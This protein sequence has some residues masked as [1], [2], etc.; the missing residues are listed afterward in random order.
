MAFCNKWVP[1]SAMAM[2]KAKPVPGTAVERIAFN[3]MA[4]PQGITISGNG[5]VWQYLYNNE[6]CNLSAGIQVGARPVQ[7][8]RCSCMWCRAQRVPAGA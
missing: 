7:C 1:I 4:P 2:A 5:T 3:R 6:T 8:G